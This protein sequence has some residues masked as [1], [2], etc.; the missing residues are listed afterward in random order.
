MSPI[1]TLR[2]RRL[3]FK[4]AN[5][6]PAPSFLTL[7]LDEIYFLLRHLKSENYIPVPE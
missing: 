2:Q 5:P 7:H 3:F 4:S 1:E 6:N